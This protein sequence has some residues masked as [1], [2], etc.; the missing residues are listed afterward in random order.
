MSAVAANEILAYDRGR[1]APGLAADVVVFDP[2]TVRDRATFAEPYAGVGGIRYVVVNGAV[3]L[4]DGKYTGAQPGIVLR[5]PGWRK[6]STPRLAGSP[7]S[8]DRPGLVDRNRDGRG[9][10]GPF[11]RHARGAGGSEARNRDAISRSRP[12]MRGVIAIDERHRS[13]GRLAGGS[14][15]P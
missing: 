2:A 12:R 7:R 5:G 3:V 10:P 11:A 6:S 1:L 15:P 13:W 8:S 14:A 4:E 9:G